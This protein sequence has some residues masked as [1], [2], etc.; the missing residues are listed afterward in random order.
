MEFRRVLFRSLRKASLQAAQSDSSACI[1]A[2]DDL[3]K[4]G[5]SFSATRKHS[6]SS[7][8]SSGVT[9]TLKA[10]STEL[11]AMF[12]FLGVRGDMSFLS[13]D[14]LYGL[15]DNIAARP[16]RKHVARGKRGAG[17]GD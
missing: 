14:N 2:C 8:A 11:L 17:R 1:A 5:D 12:G 13:E 7:D 16:A 15:G 4:P 3:L 6:S 9:G 10:V